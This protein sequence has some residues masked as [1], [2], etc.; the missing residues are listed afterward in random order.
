MAVSFGPPASNGGHDASSDLT[1]DGSPDAFVCV[2]G[3][4]YFSGCSFDLA[5]ACFAGSCDDQDSFLFTLYVNHTYGSSRTI[6]G[7]GYW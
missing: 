4:G 5:R 3:T 7:H 1:D 6:S 2:V